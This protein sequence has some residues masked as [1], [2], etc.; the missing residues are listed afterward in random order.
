[1]IVR[2]IKRK[3]GRQQTATADLAYIT[4]LA[5]Y[6]VRADAEDLEKI[7]QEID[8]PYIRDLA[9]IIHRRWS[10]RLAGVV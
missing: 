7:A 1:M 6:I 10:E 3:G 4:A 2:K 5:R 8:D 9:R